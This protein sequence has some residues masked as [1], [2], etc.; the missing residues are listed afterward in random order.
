MST[1]H[2]LVCETCSAQEWQGLL[3]EA[4]HDRAKQ[5]PS[6]CSCGGRRYLKLSFS[7]FGLGVGE[8]NE[9]VLAALPVSCHH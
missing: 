1:V 9:K 3:F 8:L 7:S 5:E 2:S 6:P 4:L